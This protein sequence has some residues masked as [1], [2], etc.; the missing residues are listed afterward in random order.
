MSQGGKS[1]GNARHWQ[2]VRSM[3][4]RATTISRRSYLAGRPPFLGA[5]M[6]R[7][8]WDHSRSAQV[9]GV[10]L[11][12]L[13]AAQFNLSDRLF[14]QALSIS[15]PESSRN[16]RGSGSQASPLSGT[17]SPWPLSLVDREPEN[18]SS[19]VRSTSV[20]RTSDISANQGLTSISGGSCTAQRVNYSQALSGQ[21]APQRRRVARQQPQ[22]NT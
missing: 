8:T 19:F 20:R 15:V 7:Q 6:K 22:R 12:C 4:S 16:G 2:P 11:T 9:T 14:Q 18:F 3:Y 1:W 21:F 13:H 10:R 17:F 5:G